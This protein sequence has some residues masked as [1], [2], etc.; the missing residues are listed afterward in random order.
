MCST[1][2]NLPRVTVHMCAF[3][4]CICAWSKIWSVRPDWALSHSENIE[5]I[6][7]VI[8]LLGNKAKFKAWSLICQVSKTWSLCCQTS[9]EDTCFKNGGKKYDQLFNPELNETAG[10]SIATPSSQSCVHYPWRMLPF[11]HFLFLLLS[12]KHSV[13]ATNLSS[14]EIREQSDR[15]CIQA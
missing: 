8:Q 5:R 13:F 1:S 7:S 11:G 10:Y 2:L 3:S 6:I 12:F 4:F 14:S 9:T 15:K